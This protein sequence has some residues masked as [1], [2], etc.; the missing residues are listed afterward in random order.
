MR[1]GHVF[2]G[3]PAHHGVKHGK[4]SSP[5]T[6]N[7][8]PRT[9]SWEPPV[10]ATIASSNEG[11]SELVASFEKH[12]EHTQATGS[13]VAR[14]IKRL[15]LRTREVVDRALRR[16]VWSDSDVDAALKEVSGGQK[17]PYEA[18]A[19]II[20]RLTGSVV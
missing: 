7:P 8:E 9:A 12:F 1:N 3:V 19:G 17:S 16:W 20:A 2:K 11:I 13:L 6:Q 5:G 18:A 14:R 15:E 4:K 10:L